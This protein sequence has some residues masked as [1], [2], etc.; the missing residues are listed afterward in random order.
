MGEILNFM[1]DMDLN[2]PVNME[3]IMKTEKS[4][5]MKDLWFAY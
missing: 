4:G 1:R 2:H 3:F 5:E